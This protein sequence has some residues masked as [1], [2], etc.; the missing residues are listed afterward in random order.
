MSMKGQIKSKCLSIH[1][2]FKANE[3]PNI[4]PD[5]SVSSDYQLNFKG[6][7]Q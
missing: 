3:C 7:K 2:C 1:V 4:L 5:Y 6:A